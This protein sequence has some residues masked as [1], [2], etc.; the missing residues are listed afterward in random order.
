MPHTDTLNGN[1]CTFRN[2]KQESKIPIK[3]QNIFRPRLDE[4]YAWNNDGSSINRLCMHWQTLRT[5]EQCTPKKKQKSAINTDR[6]RRAQN[7]FSLPKEAKTKTKQKIL[8]RLNARAH[9]RL[10]SLIFA[11]LL[12]CAH[13]AAA[14][15]AAAVSCYH[16][17]LFSIDCTIL[18]FSVVAG[19]GAQFI[20]SSVY[21]CVLLS[22]FSS[23]FRLHVFHFQ[24]CLCLL[25]LLLL[26]RVCCI[27][28]SL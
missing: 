1:F 10:R 20:Y 27:R 15:T 8:L 17:L 7:G 2:T 25:W 28:K 9:L 6:W 14:A 18:F 22:Q 12:L 21:F 26:F 16:T 19:A 4:S 3:A 5:F 23:I 13:G 24:F 11:R